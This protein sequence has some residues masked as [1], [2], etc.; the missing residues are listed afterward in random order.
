MW[1]VPALV[2]AATGTACGEGSRPNGSR[3]PA[4]ASV[5]AVDSTG[6]STSLRTRL[7]RARNL[8]FDDQ[9]DSARTVWSEVLDHARRARDSAAEGESLTWLGLVAWQTGDYTKARRL[10]E[11]ALSLKLRYDLRDQLARS[12]NALGLLAW[13]EGRLVDMTEMLRKATEIG[14]AVNDRAAVAVASANLGLVET[15]FGNFDQARQGFQLLRDVGRELGDA[16]YEGNGLTNLGMLAVS[17]GDPQAAIPDLMQALELYR[18]IEYATGEQIALAQ[19]AAAYADLGEPQLAFAT[20]DS[21]IALS[22]QLGQRDEEARNLEDLASLHKEAGNLRR[23]LN[24]YQQAEGVYEELGLLVETGTELRNVAEIHVLLRDLDGARDHALRAL[25]LHRT[26]SDR[27]EEFDDL[28]LLTEIAHLAE[29]PGEALQRLAAAR[30]LAANL[31]ASAVRLA[32]ALTEAGIADRDGDHARVHSVLTAAGP[33]LERAGPAPRFEVHRLLARAHARA[34]RFDSAAAAGR[35]AVQ[36]VERVRRKYRSSVLRTSFL[37]DRVSAYGDLVSVLLRL[38]SI[39][40]AFQI[41]DAARGRALIER[42]GA[43]R[44]EIQEAGRTAQTFEE[45]ERLLRRIDALVAALD[46]IDLFYPSEERDSATAAAMTRELE[47]TRSQYEALLIE[48]AERNTLTAT[49]MGVRRPTLAEI[50]DALGQREALIEYLVTEERVV[51]FVVLPDRARAFDSDV[52]EEDLASRVRVARDLLADPDMPSALTASAL[53]TLHSY[54]IGPARRAGALSGVERLII[55][56]HTVLNYLPFAALRDGATGR[57]LVEDFVLLHLPMAAVLPVL[58]ER[59]G[60]IIKGVRASSFAPFSSS[61]PFTR[62]ETRAIRNT[63]RTSR[64]LVGRHATE[65]RFREA[66]S[67]GDVVHAATHGVLN[68]RNPM[69][70]RIELA[71]GSADQSRNDGRLEVHELLGISI[72]SPLVFLSGCE[73]GVGV[74]W[75]TQYARGEDFATLAQAFL[76]AGARNVVATLWRIEDQGAAAFAAQ[77][78]R[79]LEELGPSGALAA[80]QRETM[81][82]ESYSAPHYWAPYQVAGA[83]DLPP[84]QESLSVSVR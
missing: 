15:A 76:Y 40:E 59:E 64:Q 67:R 69:F 73:T 35:L 55:V 26:A 31:D 20:L 46:T 53:A 58:R 29:R 38:G 39:G 48:A 51:L 5:S 21:A 36:A 70:S 23:A 9:F 72:T 49:F 11:E 1:L 83:G 62:A 45:G 77:F 81:L 30:G 57:Y 47:A 74:A 54:L 12:Y 41:A 2:A 80:A 50:Q 52:G 28:V 24:L 22:R 13:D 43:A 60:R 17:T 56:P 33:D 14:Q 65:S 44:Q 7:D 71:R 32:V 68:P 37:A 25:D 6:D 79:H 82:R 42:L 78:Y 66:L 3:E 84:P 18:S 27:F 34:N 19:L 75:S 8:Y 61:L 4:D 10:G 63:L 16:R